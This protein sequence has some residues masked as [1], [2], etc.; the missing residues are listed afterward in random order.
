MTNQFKA[1]VELLPSWKVVQAS[2]GQNEFII[3]RIELETIIAALSACRGLA[4]GTHVIVPKEPT[5]AMVVTWKKSK[6]YDGDYTDEKCATAC[7]KDMVAAA[8]SGVKP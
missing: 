8:I 2:Y 4:D 6:P 7:W 5:E 3:T 1:F